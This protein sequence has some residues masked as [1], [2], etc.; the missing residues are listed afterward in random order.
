MVKEP[1]RYLER[2]SPTF[3]FLL[4]VVTRTCSCWGFM[5]DPLFFS[6]FLISLT[7]SWTDHLSCSPPRCPDFCLSHLFSCFR[8]SGLFFC[9]FFVISHFF[10]FYS[11]CWNKS[12]DICSFYLSKDRDYLVPFAGERQPLQIYG[13]STSCEVWDVVDPHMGCFVL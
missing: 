3:Y 7:F 12:C 8:L 6:L 11:S 2:Q 4:L 13:F 1:M 10:Y 5:Y 9:F